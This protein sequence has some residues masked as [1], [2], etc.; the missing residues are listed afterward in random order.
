MPLGSTAYSVAHLATATALE[1]ALRRSAVAVPA[2]SERPAAQTSTSN[3]PELNFAASASAPPDGRRED[4][5]DEM[6][7]E[8]GMLGDGAQGEQGD[9]IADLLDWESVEALRK[10]CIEDD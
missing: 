4:E 6:H 2:P 10:S 9:G 5:Q 8:L 3:A 1:K 7:A